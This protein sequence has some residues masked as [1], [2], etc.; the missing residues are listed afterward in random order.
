[1]IG[2]P[3]KEDSTY[4]YGTDIDVDLTRTINVKKQSTVFDSFSHI[5]VKVF[6]LTGD[7]IYILIRN[8]FEFIQ[9]NDVSTPIISVGVFLLE[10][11]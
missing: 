11:S 6:Q 2:D 1:M 9:L 3:T 8:I 5:V 7:P 4:L 10:T